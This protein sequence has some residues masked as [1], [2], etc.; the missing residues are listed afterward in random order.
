MVVGASCCVLFLVFVFHSV[1]HPL[2]A[3]SSVRKKIDLMVIN[4]AAEALSCATEDE[5]EPDD[6]ERDAF[7]SLL[8]VILRPKTFPIL[9]RRATN[10]NSCLIFH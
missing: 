9:L 5:R 7:V 3:E 2:Q 4:T 6:L 10:Q 8:S 1:F